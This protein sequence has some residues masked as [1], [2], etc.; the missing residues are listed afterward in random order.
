MTSMGG[1]MDHRQKVGDCNADF[2]GE[3]RVGRRRFLRLAALGGGVSLFLA[4]APGAVR[5]AGKAETLLL[6]CM[7]YR[8]VDDLVRYMDGLGL[9]DSYDHIILAGASAGAVH[10]A[11]AAWH[12]TFWEHVQAAIDLHG[13]RKVMVIDHRDCGGYRI[14]LGPDHAADAASERAAH[15]GLLG[16]LAEAMA[17]RHPALEVETYLMALDGSVERI[18]GS[19][20]KI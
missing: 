2:A 15:A 13:T 9:T 18:G 19:A 20:P 5:A 8:L 6:S 17:E 12:E 16:L 7:D 10:P 4:L 11:F 14:A 1:V 3:L